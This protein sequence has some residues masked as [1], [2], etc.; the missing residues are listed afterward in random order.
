MREV[1]ASL[2]LQ[3][4]AK[5]LGLSLTSHSGDTT[6][7]TDR[8]ALNQIILNLATN[9]IKFSDRGVVELAMRWIDIEGHRSL[10]LSVTDQ[11]I[12]IRPEDQPRLFQAFTRLN[13][14]DGLA[15]EGTGLGLHLSQRLAGLLGGR[16]VCR[17]EFGHGSRFSLQLPEL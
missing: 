14:D 6:I 17:S 4:K 8:R 1:V 15:R 3:A 10:E 7:R 13:S 16:I 9:A 11:G 5:N 2:R 12:G